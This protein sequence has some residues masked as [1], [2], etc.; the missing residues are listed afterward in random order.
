MTGVE[1]SVTGNEWSGAETEDERLGTG[2]VDCR[3]S[4]NN[5]KHWGRRNMCAS[6]SDSDLTQESHDM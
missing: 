6:D 2:T 3:V 4:S 1:G 5:G